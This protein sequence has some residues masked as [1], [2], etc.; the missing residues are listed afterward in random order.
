MTVSVRDIVNGPDF[1]P[2]PNS[3]WG[4]VIQVGLSL[5][6]RGRSPQYVGTL[7]GASAGVNFNQF[8]NT[9][10][11]TLARRA[12]KGAISQFYNAGKSGDTLGVVGAI[13]SGMLQ[14][15][16]SDVLALPIQPQTVSVQTFGNDINQINQFGNGT[17]ASDHQVVLAACLANF[18][19][20]AEL[21]FNAGYNLWF[22]ILPEN[23]TWTIRMERDWAQWRIYRYCLEFARRYNCLVFNYAACSSWPETQL[24]LAVTASQLIAVNNTVAAGSNGANIATLT[25]LNVAST[26]GFAAAG[27]AVVVTAGG[28]LMFSYTGVGATTFTG[29]TSQAIGTIA[30]GNVV[31]Q[32]KA[33]V[34]GHG[35]S[36]GDC[37]FSDFILLPAPAG[38][39]NNTGAV[40]HVTDANNINWGQ[41]V[42]AA[43]AAVS[44][45]I[46]RN[47][48]LP[49]IMADQPSNVHWAFA[50][51]QKAKYQV[52]DSIT[53]GSKDTLTYTNR[54]GA[55]IVGS[56]IATTTSFRRRSSGMC[57]G[58]GGTSTGSAGV[59]GVIARGWDVH[60]LVG[61]AG[62]TVVG[63]IVS[64]TDPARNQMHYQQ[65]L[66]TAG[67]ANLHLEFRMAHALP[68]AWSA[69][70]VKAADAWVMPLATPSGYFFV[71]K[72][73]GTTG[74]TEPTWVN[75][76]GAPTTD[77][78]VIWEC[79]QGWIN[80]GLT[81]YRLQSEYLILAN[82]AGANDAIGNMSFGLYDPSA[83]TNSL[84]DGDDQ[85]I[86]Q[87]NPLLLEGQNEYFDTANNNAFCVIPV[88]MTAPTVAWRWWIYAG[89]SAT[90]LVNRA[91]W[92]LTGLQL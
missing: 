52:L 43:T 91:S 4:S 17:A 54:D 73:A 77:G 33:Q 35:L 5:P 51:A 90:V 66:I 23:G 75:V 49:G 44:G 48:V 21:V 7:N 8:T 65:L 76:P 41:N 45:S 18:E 79:R 81:R 64:H 69:L 85:A 56:G 47:S 1:S 80:D 55:N 26:T 71:C 31:S 20:F 88:A 36:E 25:T 12:L 86:N 40:I 70:A 28:N 84:I 46:L 89:K 78:S 42:T 60:D 92:Y 2:K 53:Y 30:T 37:I 50:G 82:G 68:T 10:P 3:Q 57:E 74:S 29:C 15:W 27:N 58:S 83:A 61:G 22:E 13:T 16:S 11:I 14:R 63:S 19:I 72:T 24:P 87:F 38:F 62:A 32:V 67:A 59:S 34:T 39:V 6:D 9:D